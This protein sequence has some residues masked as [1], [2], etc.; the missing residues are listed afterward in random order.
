[1]VWLGGRQYLTDE[2]VELLSA[3]A[4]HSAVAIES[5]AAYES[6]LESREMSTF[7]RMTSFLLHDLRNNVSTLSMLAQNAQKHIENPAFRKNLVKNLGSSVADMKRLLEKLSDLRS[8]TGMKLSAADPDQLVRDILSELSIVEN[9]EVQCLLCAK[10]SITTDREKLRSIIRNLLVNAI[11]AMP[12][13][14]SLKI[15]TQWVSTE[16]GRNVV[17]L[18]VRD[19]G[20]GMDE[21]FIRERLF[22]AFQTTKSKGLG[23]G[24][25][26]CRESVES[27]G[28]TISVESKLGEGTTFT[29]ALPDMA[30]MSEREEEK[31][32]AL[33]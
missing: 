7:H 12:K 26:Q 8:A 22:K 11:E 5:L 24:M 21:A 31:T 18:T 15:E 16:N 1:M 6:L 27:L 23:I 32:A 3:I 29:V 19:T 9:I 13:G 25:F 30:A 20:V 33:A 10:D 14:G 4:N 2:D 28:G 17:T